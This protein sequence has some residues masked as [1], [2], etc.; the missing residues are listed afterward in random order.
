LTPNPLGALELTGGWEAFN[1]PGAEFIGQQELKRLA[2]ERAMPAPFF[3]P[4]A[5]ASL[6]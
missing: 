4:G 3:A 1:H 5:V 2:E 6:M